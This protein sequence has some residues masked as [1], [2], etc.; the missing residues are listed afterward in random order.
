MPRM[1]TKKEDTKATVGRTDEI[2]KKTSR[3]LRRGRIQS[4]RQ[5]AHG[6]RNWT[7]KV[8]LRMPTGAKEPGRRRR[9]SK[10]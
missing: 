5:W 2:K 3:C 7:P 8:E 4:R 6:L 9:R 10:T 1:T